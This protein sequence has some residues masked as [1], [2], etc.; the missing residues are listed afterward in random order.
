MEEF[1]K[2]IKNVVYLFSGGFLGVYIC[3]NSL[4]CALKMGIQVVSHLG[5]FNLTIFQ[6]CNGVKAIHIQ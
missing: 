6:F 5:C 4:T 1:S 3:Q 2:V